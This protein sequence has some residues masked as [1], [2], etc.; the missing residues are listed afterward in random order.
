MDSDS[1]LYVN[2]RHIQKNKRPLFF[3]AVALKK[4]YVSFHLMPIYVQPQLL[5]S[6]SPELKAR[7]QGKSCFHF[8]RVNKP[9]FSELAALTKNGF[10]SYKEQGFV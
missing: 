4:N 1:E 3:G 6:I 2:T 9:L 5:E 8:T 7:M 10:A